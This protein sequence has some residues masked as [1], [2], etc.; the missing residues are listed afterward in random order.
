M[1][2]VKHILTILAVIGNV[3]F[4]LWILYNGISEGFQGTLLEKISYLG[5]MVLLAVN[6]FLLLSGKDKQT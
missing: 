3:L 6:S 2:E 4:I 5:L 1:K